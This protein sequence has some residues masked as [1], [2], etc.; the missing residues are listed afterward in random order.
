M[1]YQFSYRN[2]HY[3][4]YIIHSFH[5]HSFLSHN[6]NTPPHNNTTQ[7]PTL[8]PPLH[9]SL[10]LQGLQNKDITWEY[11]FSDNFMHLI[12]YSWV[13][14][15][16]ILEFVED[17]V[18]HEEVKVRGTDI[19]GVFYLR[20]LLQLFVMKIHLCN[21]SFRGDCLPSS[22][23]ILYILH[24]THTLPHIFLLQPTVWT[25]AHAG[26]AGE[27]HGALLAHHRNAR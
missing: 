3:S 6:N 1:R 14:L 12:T 5:L 23:C 25:A 4:Y 21:H 22:F 11:L 18:L 13:P 24:F 27:R 9:H 8:L 19:V 17:S 16:Y 26:A 10:L 20:M 7:T 15:Q 2:T